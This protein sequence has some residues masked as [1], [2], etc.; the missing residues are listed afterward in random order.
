MSRLTWI[1]KILNQKPESIFKFTTAVKVAAIPVVTGMFLYVALWFFLKI[2][3]V[4]FNANGLFDV[5]A[6]E[7]AYYEYIFSKSYN[8]SPYIILFE[9]IAF[10]LG[11]YLSTLLLRPFKMIGD[12]CED[13]INGKEV[14]YD[15][16][17]F[18]DLKLLTQFSEFFFNIIESAKKNKKLEQVIIPT[19]FTRI[20]GPV[21]EGTF[22]LQYFLIILIV[23]IIGAVLVHQFIFSI[24][25]GLIDISIDSIGQNNLLRQILIDQKSL[26]NTL[27][28]GTIFIYAL[29]YI[30]MSINLYSKVAAPAFGI[31]ATMRSFLKGK[32]SNRVHFLGF[33][34]IRNESRSMNKFLDKVSR[35]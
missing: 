26:L 24:Y 7:S 15:P 27:Y 33:G 11:Y 13:S 21:F 25:G 10:L 16:D 31:F 18:T 22:F 12:Y 29:L 4:T 3:L 20:H 35:E 32:Y 14:I 34:Y 28:Y 8:L 2:N 19:K 5:V 23:A 9:I 17:F 1:K 6:L 30:S